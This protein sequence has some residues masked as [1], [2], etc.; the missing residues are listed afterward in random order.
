MTTGRR[1]DPADWVA[2]GSSRGRGRPRI[3]EEVSCTMPSAQVAALDAIAAAR[4]VKRQDVLREA[5]AEYLRLEVE[6][7]A[8]GS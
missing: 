4:G 7:E 6:R 2:Y 5:V 1:R 8:R 3:G